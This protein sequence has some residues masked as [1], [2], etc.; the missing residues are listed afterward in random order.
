VHRGTD[1]ERQRLDRDLQTLQTQSTSPA[2]LGVPN[3]F[4]PE[5]ALLL[6][7]AVCQAP[8]AP[9]NRSAGPL[10]SHRAPRAD[11]GCNPPPRTQARLKGASLCC[12]FAI[13]A[14]EDGKDSFSP[15][16]YDIQSGL[17]SFPSGGDAQEN[18]HR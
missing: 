3:G 7:K 8:G 2:T 18:S 16:V 4:A 5:G 17:F 10:P 14:Y 11:D 15:R 13:G 9:E 1:C 12:P 6:N